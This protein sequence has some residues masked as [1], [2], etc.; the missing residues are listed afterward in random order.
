MAKATA[1]KKT[2]KSTTTPAY[3]I[4]KA[5]VEKAIG[6]GLVKDEKE[7]NSIEGALQELEPGFYEE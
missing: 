6:H 3:E 1:P 4:V 5:F 7:K 2:N